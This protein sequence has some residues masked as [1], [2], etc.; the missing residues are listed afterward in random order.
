M[1][2]GDGSV[3]DPALIRPPSDTVF[4]H[5]MMMMMIEVM[6][7]IV[8]DPDGR[9]CKHEIIFVEASMLDYIS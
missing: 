4:R 9:S 7:N 5:C 8:Q 3:S 2:I 1:L 6:I